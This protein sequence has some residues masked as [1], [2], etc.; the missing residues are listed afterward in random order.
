MGK[1]FLVNIASSSSRLA[2]IPSF[3]RFEYLINLLLL[4]WLMSDCVNMVT[5]MVTPRWCLLSVYC[6][7]AV[8]IHIR[9]FTYQISSQPST[10]IEEEIKNGERLRYRRWLGPPG[11]FGLL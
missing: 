10:L 2:I 6:C 3:P 7:L 9:S 11:E 5:V 4:K 1:G 8:P